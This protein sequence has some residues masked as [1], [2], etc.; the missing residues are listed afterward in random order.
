MSVKNKYSIKPVKRSSRK[1]YVL[2]I[3]VLVL[4]SLGAGFAVYHKR[5]TDKQLTKVASLTDKQ[6]E[7]INFDPPTDQEVSDT[8]KHK[9]DIV[10]ENQQ[11]D[12]PTSGKRAVSPI[13]SYIDKST[14]N[15]YVTGVFEEGGT[16]TLT[17]T[18]GGQSFTKTSSGFE[19][20]SY[21]QCAPIDISSFSLSGSYSATLKYESPT[22]L[23]S[24]TTQTK[25]L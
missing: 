5:N 16:C 18:K 20:A 11:N 22:A 6:K 19:N 1:L 17:L 8:D 14:A 2:V 15:A 13:I 25:N 4:A 7:D 3:A 23:G 10:K 9:D 24:S 12:Q 21:T